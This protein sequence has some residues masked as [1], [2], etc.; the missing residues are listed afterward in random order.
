LTGSLRL[1]ILSLI[2]FFIVGL[3]LLPFVKVDDA[4]EQGKKTEAV[5]VGSGD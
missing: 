4:I 2:A 1:G 3:I 5:F